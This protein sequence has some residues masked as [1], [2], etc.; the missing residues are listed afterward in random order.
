MDAHQQREEGAD[1]HR[2][3][4]EGEVLETDGAMVGTEEQGVGGKG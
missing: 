1:S 3:E 2:D 4:R